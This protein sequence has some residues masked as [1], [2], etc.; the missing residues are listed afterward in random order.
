MTIRKSS[1]DALHPYFNPVFFRGL[2]RRN[3]PKLLCCSLLLF[4]VLPLPLIFN[5]NNYSRLDAIQTCVRIDR[6]LTGNFWLYTIAVAAI[7]VFLG[8][9]ATRH[10]TR[11]SAVDYYHALPIRREGLLLAHWLE[12]AVHFGSALLFNLL[13]TAVYFLTVAEAGAGYERVFGKL[14]AVGGLLLPVFLLFYTLTVFCGMLC[15][16]S[17]MQLIVTGLA[18]GAYP[19]ARLLFLAFAEKSVHYIDLYT[20]LEPSWRYLSPALRLFY[21]SGTDNSYE[22]LGGQE[23]TL[24]HWETPFLWWEIVLWI[25]AAALLFVGAVWLYRRRHVERAGMPVVFGGVASAVRWVTVL[26]GTLGLGWIFENLGNGPFWLLFGFLL[27][28]FLAFILVGSLLTKNPKQMFE[29]WRR[30]IVFMVA[31]CLLFVGLMWGISA[32]SR[33]VPKHVDSITIYFEGDNYSVREYRDP[34]VIEA[35]MALREKDPIEYG[36]NV[37]GLSVPLYQDAGDQYFNEYGDYEFYERHVTV[38]AYVKI[39]G[40][41]IPYK[42]ISYLRSELGELYRAIAD[43]EEFQ[44]GWEMMLDEIARLGVRT[45][46]PFRDKPVNGLTQPIRVDLGE[47]TMHHHFAKAYAAEKEVFFNNLLQSNYNDRLALAP[48]GEDTLASILADCRDVS[49]ETFQSPMYAEMRVYNAV[50]A[51]DY[52][53]G[54]RML[55]LGVYMHD[56]ALY[57]EVMGMEEEEFYGALA[58]AVLMADPE[59]ILVAKRVH[60]SFSEGDPHVMRVNDREQVIEILRGLSMFSPES[61]D[62][63]GLCDLTVYDDGYGVIFPNSGVTY[64][65]WFIDGKVPAFVKS[66]LG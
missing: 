46:D 50:R 18:L 62:Y 28:A 43:S 21:L 26:L 31:F 12:G 4:F 13:L 30:L 10:L 66:A 55:R 44:A 1:S 33:R 29:G 11:R 41:V 9:L 53:Y 56:P 37:Y 24:Y 20:M 23:R 57:R 59:G 49:S 19:L 42:S 47:V 7:A 5:V 35:W 48:V 17:L 63:Y 3:W 54:N 25:A 22:W 14:F 51:D 15:G 58:D 65:T 2:L 39:H 32:L 60:Y 52:R 64:V 34:A 36:T 40:I 45:F 8:I 27:G 38:T 61:N 16:T 6:A